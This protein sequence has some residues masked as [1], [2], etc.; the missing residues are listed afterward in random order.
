ME[1][2]SQS[3]KVGKAPASG[4]RGLGHGLSRF[5]QSAFRDQQLQASSS[6]DP[7]SSDIGVLQVSENFFCNRSDQSFARLVHAFDTC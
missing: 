5:G 7:N 6:W 4:N 2:N 1:L 3:A